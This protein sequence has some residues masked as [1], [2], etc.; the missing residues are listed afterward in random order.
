MN[1][2]NGPDP[3]CA[4]RLLAIGPPKDLKAFCRTEDWPSQFTEVEPLELSPKRRTWQFSTPEPPLP[5][6]RTL[7]TRHPRLLFLLDYDTGRAKGLASFS[8]SKV[9]HHRIVYT[10]GTA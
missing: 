6:L 7:S 8:N 9:K 10:Q 3:R 1:A 5:Y 4:C 2:D